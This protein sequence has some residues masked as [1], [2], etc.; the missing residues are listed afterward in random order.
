MAE[1]A[2]RI[3]IEMLNM[4]VGKQDQY[5]SSFGGLN[6]YTFSPH[7]VEV[8]PLA[9]SPK[10]KRQLEQDLMLFFTGSS[11]QSSS[12]LRE[13]RQASRSDS[14]VIESLH[15]IKRLALE[16]KERLEQGY[17]NEIGQLLHT[18]WQHKKNLASN[19]SNPFIDQCY[20]A[21][22]EAGAL[23]GKITGAGGGGFL[24]LYCPRHQQ[25]GVTRALSE[26]G[27]RRMDFRFEKRG[28]EVLWQTKWPASF[29]ANNGTSHGPR[30]SI[31][32]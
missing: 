2:S 7:G 31:S 23:E 13:Q 29:R 17:V 16:T 3:E 14:R 27:L 26:K 1:L 32:G 4:P 6:A 15:V 22:L 20:D 11:R 25:T 8:Q 5:A 28:A 9:M 24:M 30:K 18:N 21:A 12:I 19:V 10:A